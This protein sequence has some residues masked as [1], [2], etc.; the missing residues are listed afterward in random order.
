[1]KARLPRH[2][3]W[4]IR[5]SFWNSDREYLLGD[6]EEEFQRRSRGFGA[7]AARRWLRRQLLPALLLRGRKADRPVPLPAPPTGDST[8][9]TALQDLRYAFRGLRRQ[10]GF[11]A[12]AVL[13][14]GLAIGANGA[15]FTLVNS[16][17][18]RELP[19]EDPERLTL[20]WTDF[21]NGQFLRGD[22]SAPDFEDWVRESR[23]FES[24]AA[25]AFSSRTWTG[26]ETPQRLD[27]TLVTANLFDTLG[28]LPQLGRGFTASEESLDANVAIISDGM[29][30]RAFGA[31][32][33]VLGR[34]LTFNGRDVEVVGVMPP[35]FAFPAP[36]IDVWA[37]V[38]RDHPFWSQRNQH[39]LVGVGRMRE[40]V[41]LESARQEMQAVSRGL[42]LRFPQSHTKRGS[43]VAS[44]HDETVHS[45]RTPLLLLQGAVAFVLFVACINVANLL[46]G[47]AVDRGREIAVRTALGAGRW[48]LL[49]QMLTEGAL[50][51]AIGTALGLWV[52]STGVRLLLRFGGM[53]IPRG[54]EVAIDAGVVVFLL[55]LM[56]LTALIFGM[57]PAVHAFRSDIDALLRAGG[58][59]PVTLSRQRARQWLIGCEVALSLIL[60]VG[61]G[62]L[63][64]SFLRLTLVDPG[65]RPERLLALQL[66]LPAD[67]YPDNAEQIA[68][69][70]QV[71]EDL[72]ALP[73]VES[74]AVVSHLPPTQDFW[75]YG[76]TL[77]DRPAPA[78]A[79]D[80]PRA[81]YRLA[82][83]GYFATMGMPLL[84]GRG[85]SERDVAGSP[86]TLVINESMAR[87]YWPGRT[88]VGQ[89]LEFF[90]C[91]EQ[92]CTVVGVVGDVRHS[93]LAAGDEPAMYGAHAQK[94]DAD[95]RGLFFVVRG[96]GASGP[97]I[98]AVQQRIWERDGNLPFGWVGSLDARID[99]TIASERLLAMLVGLF[100]TLALTMAAVGIYGVISYAVSTRTREIGVRVA[101]G[102]GP[103]EILSLIVRQGMG[104]TV[105]GMVVGLLSALGLTR[106][107]ESQLFGV[108]PND[109]LTIAVVC[110]L[111]IVVAL[112]A[113]SIPALRGIKVDP[114]TALRHDG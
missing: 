70:R 34:R 33:D 107:L 100:A 68:F 87:R 78:E 57:A 20:L 71:I 6:L 17:L 12:I 112:V 92:R 32:P 49:R 96:S 25:Y 63:I 8:I 41:G 67:R 2:V 110:L 43:F 101:L 38:P 28:V 59:G 85:L 30:R 9:A 40:G 19:Y 77:P 31:D 52:A 1:M 102:A 5:A 72:E 99:A 51:A 82:S 79:R 90:A 18:L 108:V 113:C 35:G 16:V 114:A 36:T 45:A 64:H 54:E 46:I 86:R 24:L 56:S 73:G 14:I 76:L 21:D 13:T 103:R 15:I 11:T 42:A 93:G 88:A 84:E 55:G 58:R 60:L 39:F 10:P 91:R 22:T 4:A 26:G 105:G 98:E 65:F 48:R 69:T 53:R 66:H 81:S 104:W 75:R 109:P 94:P 83:P 80:K 3:E 97:L 50:L 29:W 111:L 106:F 27:A 74:A 7:S 95:M 62:L 61:A 44:L 37:P 47:R 23:S 89:S